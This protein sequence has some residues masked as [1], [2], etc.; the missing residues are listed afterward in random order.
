MS[1]VSNKQ[2]IFLDATTLYKGTMGMRYKAVDVGSR[3]IAKT[4]E[5]AWQKSELS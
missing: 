2:E 1:Q 4:M 5:T 3:L